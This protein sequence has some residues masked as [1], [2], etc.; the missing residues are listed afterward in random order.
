MILPRVTLS[1]GLYYTEIITMT[2][3]LLLQFLF[4]VFAMTSSKT[5]WIRRLPPKAPSSE[6][7]RA[8]IELLSG[9][10]AF[11]VENL[12]SVHDESWFWETSEPGNWKPV[13]DNLEQFIDRCMRGE[14]GAPREILPEVL[15]TYEC[16]LRNST[17]AIPL[18]SMERLA[19]L[20]SD[21]NLWV[22]CGAAR[23][24][25]IAL[26]SSG[27]RRGTVTDDIVRRVECHYDGSKFGF[28]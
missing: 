4:S 1:E 21:D 8:A 3:F 13:L 19:M 5:D 10:S 11:L 2:K 12:A 20:L 16:V 18:P 9:E 26:F 6:S 27:R 17:K 7:E 25:R 28:R 14:E 23:A 22:V 15:R 24:L